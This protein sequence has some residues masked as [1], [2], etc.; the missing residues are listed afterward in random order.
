[1]QQNKFSQRRFYRGWLF[2]RKNK[3]NKI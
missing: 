3:N 2:I 1:L